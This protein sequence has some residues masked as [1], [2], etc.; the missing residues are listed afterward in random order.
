[1]NDILGILALLTAPALLVSFLIPESTSHQEKN[2][3]HRDKPQRKR[4]FPFGNRRKRKPLPTDQPHSS[5]GSISLAVVKWFKIIGWG[6]LILFLATYVADPRL[7]LMPDIS[8]K[9]LSFW[10]AACCLTLVYLSE[11]LALVLLIG[12]TWYIYNV[13]RSETG[14]Q[15]GAVPILTWIITIGIVS[16]GFLIGKVFGR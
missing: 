6:A 10:V 13:G 2:H 7:S 5:R 12:G 3:T 1:M 9:S 4:R 8:V 16:L 11:L 15:Y 14:F